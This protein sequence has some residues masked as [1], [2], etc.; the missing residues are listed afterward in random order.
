ML[1]FKISLLAAFV[2]F[3]LLG[4]AA[5]SLKALLIGMAALIVSLLIALANF[6]RAEHRAERELPS[7]L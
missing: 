6:V 3:T 1:R 7:M 4:M 5:P 2:F